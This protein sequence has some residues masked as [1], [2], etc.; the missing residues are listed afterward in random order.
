[1]RMSHAS[2]K[3]QLD[4]LY[5]RYNSREWV[6]PDPLEYL[7]EYPTFQDREVVGLIASSL[8][9]GRVA[10][11]LKSVSAVLKKMGPSPHLF[12]RSSTPASLKSTF[13]DFKHRFTIAEELIAMLIGLKDVIER[14]GTLYACFLSGFNHND[15]TV[16]PGLSSLVHELTRGFNGRHNSLLP[17]PQKGSACKRLNLFLRWMVREDRVD[18]GGWQEVPPKKLI[19]PIDTHMHRIG[20]LLNLTG[21][22]SAGMPTAIEI[23]RAFREIAPEDPVRYDFALTRLGIRKDAHVHVLGKESGSRGPACAKGV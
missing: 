15:K 21:R 5:A 16:L 6:H 22:K 3:L 20:I 7:Y 12:L 13:H 8:A 17:L 9:Y 14:H 19:V 11:I 1:M 18:P 23:T 10:Q 2:I 4:R